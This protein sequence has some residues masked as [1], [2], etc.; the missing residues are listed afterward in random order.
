MRT[1][2]KVNLIYCECGCRNLILSRDI[3]GR[4]HNFAP[5]HNIGGEKAVSN[6]NWKGGRWTKGNYIVVYR[7]NHPFADKRGY[8]KEHRLIWELY[9]N[10][11]LL[12]WS[13]VHHLDGDTFNNAIDNL[14]AM[15]KSDH[16]KLHIKNRD[17]TRGK[18]S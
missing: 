16:S 2:L 11:I 8:V 18:W 3:Q 12:A 10:A 9:N 14:K 15:T 6:R 17:R 7:P 5:G 4:P 13:D 1:I